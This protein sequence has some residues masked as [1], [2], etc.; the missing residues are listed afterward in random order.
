M[1]IYLFVI[2]SF[3]FMNHKIPEKS[4]PKSDQTE[5][6]QKIKKTN[7]LVALWDFK[8]KEGGDRKAIGISK[9]RL[10]EEDG[11]IPRVNEGPISGY[12]AKFGNRA[13]LKIS[14]QNTGALNIFGKSQ[15]ITVIAWV[16]WEVNTGFIGGMW[17]VE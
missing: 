10:K 17:N 11:T 7:G 3:L 5:K 14:N 16:K 1:K 12:S 2:F 4:I 6:V 13:F 15:G 9:F 8:E